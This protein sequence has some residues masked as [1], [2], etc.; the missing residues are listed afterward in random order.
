MVRPALPDNHI[1]EDETFIYRYDVYGNLVEKRC[2][3]NESE[4]H[5]FTWDSQHRLS[6]YSHTLSWSDGHDTT[7]AEYL[8]DALG[9]RIGK[10]TAVLNPQGHPREAPQLTWYG[11][12]GDNLVL[13]ERDGQ[14]IHTVYQPGSFV[15]LLR[16]EGDIP[17]PVQTLADTLTQDSGITF[18]PEVTQQLH[19]LEQELRDGELSPHSQQW[20]A[21]SQL[22]PERLLPLLKPLPEPTTPVVHLYHCDHLGTP[23]ALINTQGGIDWRAEFDP[24]GN[25][26]DGSNPQRL[27]QPIRMQGQHYD[28]ESGM[29]YN[30]HRYY[31]PALGRYISQDPIGLAGGMNL[32]QYTNN[33]VQQ[34]DPLGLVN[35]G[36]GI[37][38]AK[39]QTSINANPGPEATTFRPE[40]A[41][42]HIH[43]GK[44]DGPRVS[45]ET[46]QPFSEADAVKMTKEQR[47]FCKKLTDESK[48]IISKRAK[49]IF[50]FGKL[51]GFIGDISTLHDLSLGTA[52]EACVQG[53]ASLCQVFILMGGEVDDNPPMI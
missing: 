6:Q 26:V 42:E 31:D 3:G 44:N 36:D 5:H 22:T 4:V 37:P 50:K 16:I 23:I 21:V 30:R 34:I 52:R 32:Y 39:G 10:R 29:H 49:Q 45:T 38:G 9:R 17:E 12:E 1:T 33:P 35:I 25:Q 24:W 41:P 46:W 2:H 20:L 48:K 27:Y 15:P 8:Y 47:S 14:R 53:D 7:W 51:F 11:W 43:L 13:T 28:E 18:T 40:H 19:Q